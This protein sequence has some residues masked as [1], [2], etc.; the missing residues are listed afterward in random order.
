KEYQ[1]R[2]VCVPDPYRFP[3]NSGSVRTPEARYRGANTTASKKRNTKAYQSKF[4][5]TIPVVYPTVAKAN[6]MEG[7]T[8][9]AHILKP[10]LYQLSDLP[11]RKCSAPSAFLR[12]E[13]SPMTMR[14]M[15]YTTTIT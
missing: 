13:T 8:L 10:I 14:A 9:V 6:N 5:A 7:P 3:I 11:A 2:I 12:D 1:A 4:T 15:R